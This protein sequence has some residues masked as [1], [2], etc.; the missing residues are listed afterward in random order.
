[1]GHHRLINSN[2]GITLHAKAQH[3][4]LRYFE[5]ELKGSHQLIYSTHSPF[6]IDPEHFERVRI[7]QDKSIDAEL[8]AYI[9]KDGTTVLEDIFA[10]SADS[11]F[12]LQG[13][14]GY[15]LH[16]TLFV[17]PYTVVVEGAAD[18]LFLQAMSAI[19]QEETRTGLDWILVGRLRRL[20]ARRRCR[21]LLPCS[22]LRK[23]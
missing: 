2:S 8:N 17:G 6:M 22:V 10:A 11:L 21:P 23:A 20:V 9:G 7:V 19:L 13:A 14:L 16:Q 18:L 12:P 3:D 15:E 4:L 5:T 1:L